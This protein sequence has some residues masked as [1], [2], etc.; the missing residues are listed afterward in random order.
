VL[1]NPEAVR[2]A[3]P[4]TGRDGADAERRPGG[5]LPAE[6]R[7]NETDLV[8]RHFAAMRGGPDAEDE[9]LALFAEDAEYVAVAA[10]ARHRHVGRDQIRAGVRGTRAVV[11]WGAW[12][13]VDRVEVVGQRVR[14]AWTC[15][16]PAFALPVRG[17][18]E[19]TI[20]GG[21]IVRLQTTLAS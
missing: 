21:K 18:N 12:L 7:V 15:H 4:G 1:D 6:V 19:Y 14:A 10:D 2:A 16:S 13:N 8:G 17:V 5:A 9:L 3:P 20:Q 11:P